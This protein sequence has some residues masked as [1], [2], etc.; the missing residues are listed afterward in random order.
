VV[1]V[2]PDGEAKWDFGGGPF[3]L[4]FGADGTIY[5]AENIPAGCTTECVR[6]SA[7]HALTPAG[8]E[9]W[10][11]SPGIKTGGPAVNTPRQ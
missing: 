1:A 8:D 2:G 7:L 10:A 4:A 11:F 3:S 6:S 9:K 5:V